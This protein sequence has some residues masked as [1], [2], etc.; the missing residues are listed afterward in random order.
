MRKLLCFI[1]PLTIMLTLTIPGL[2]AGN[3]SEY[4]EKMIIY[5]RYHQEDAKLDL[6]L[7]N[8]QLS[9]IDEGQAQK[10]A[11]IMDF[12][13]WVN[14]DMDIDAEVLPDGLP[15]DDSLCIVVLGYAL[16]RN[17][18][19]QD[20]LIG[21][22]KTALACAEKY[23]NAYIVCTGGGTARNNDSVTE[24]GEMARW[25]RK[26]GIDKNRIIEEEESLSTVNNAQ[27]TCKLLNEQYP[28]IEHLAIVTSD[29]HQGRGPLLFEAESILQDYNLNVTAIASYQTSEHKLDSLKVQANALAHLADLSVEDADKPKL[30]KLTAF[31]ISG[32]TQ[33]LVGQ[34]LN[35]RVY[36]L[37][38][39]GYKKDVTSKVN[40]SGFDL[41]KAGIQTIIIQYLEA[42]EMYKTSID[43]EFLP[44][45]TD[46]D[47]E[48]M[49]VPEEV[50]PVSTVAAKPETPPPFLISILVVLVCL[51]C[52]LLILKKRR[53]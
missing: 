8:A 52:I 48:T 11:K 43:V 1:L 49:P 31:Q 21:R 9:E 7:L 14:T 38:S 33:C 34:E 10:W 45:P 42:G 24:A 13:S 20:E 6:E 51:L 23:P 29:Y 47:E 5:Y 44:A 16:K 19:M 12:W 39:N 50:V 27:F 26:K 36:A 15:E 32:E 35:L 28:Q 2:A 53:K 22:L 30:S 4:I 41:S 46:A 3:G 37:Y 18:D 40:Y 17:G 25:L